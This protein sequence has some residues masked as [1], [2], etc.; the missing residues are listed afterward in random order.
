MPVVVGFIPT[1]LGFAALRAGREEAERRGRP[2]IVVNVIRDGDDGD[3]R[4]AAPGQLDV[5]HE[6]TRGAGVRV[7]VRQERVEHDRSEALVR[8]ATEEQAELLVIGIR[9]SEGV[10][11]HLIGTTAQK[12]LLDSPCDVLVV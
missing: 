6:Q 10:A 11:A 8:I 4:H 3:P 5:V 9:R 1:P 2:L 7:E 12:L